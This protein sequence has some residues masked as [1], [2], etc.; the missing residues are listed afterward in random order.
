MFS[1]KAFS[2]PNI[3][4]LVIS[5][6]FL[7]CPVIRLENRSYVIVIFV[8]FIMTNVVTDAFASDPVVLE[9]R[10]TFASS[11]CNT[12][13]VFVNGKLAALFSASPSL[14]SR[15]FPKNAIIGDAI[16]SEI[17]TDPTD[18]LSGKILGFRITRA[19]AENSFRVLTLD[20][21]S[22]WNYDKPR[23]KV[24]SIPD[25]LIILGTKILNRDCSIQ[26]TADDDYYES[27]Q[28]YSSVTNIISSIVFENQF[29]KNN[30]VSG[31]KREAIIVLS[32]SSDI[33]KVTMGN[34]SFNQDR[35]L[36]DAVTLANDDPC[37]TKTEHMYNTVTYADKGKTYQRRDNVW[38]CTDGQ[39][40]GGG[41]ITAIE[42][43]RDLRYL[44]IRSNEVC[45][46]VL[47]IPVNLIYL[48]YRNDDGTGSEAW[49][50]CLATDDWTKLSDKTTIVTSTH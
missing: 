14:F 18:Y 33:F 46:K 49:S 22:Y 19:D 48:I 23:K 20:N 37:L 47:G 17:F 36:R 32:D 50:R 21:K 41:A 43:N 4:Q 42:F 12:G 13:E 16:L 34:V 31:K 10:R 29:N 3:S 44:E 8:C 1:L 26:A 27:N 30:Y 11:E 6:F 9:F 45:S 38:F 39:L 7:K 24:R 35:P 5:S 25:D 40:S 28:Y 15:N 2:T